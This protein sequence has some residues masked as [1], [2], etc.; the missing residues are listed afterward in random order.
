MREVIP[1]EMFNKKKTP[2]MVA[3]LNKLGVKA[4][5]T[6]NGFE[7]DFDAFVQYAKITP[8]GLM[9][10]WLTNYG[11]SNLLWLLDDKY[12]EIYK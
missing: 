8:K 11:D 9:P 6:D 12:K 3:L 2:K 7:Y 5:E 4:N 10:V 1:N